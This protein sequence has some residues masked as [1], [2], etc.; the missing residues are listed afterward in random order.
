MIRRPPRSTLFPY[1]TLF[2][3]VLGCE[4]GLH[5]GALVVWVSGNGQARQPDAAV[6]REARLAGPAAGAA[7]H[8][9]PTAA[10]GTAGTAPRDRESVGEGKR[11]DIGG[12]RIN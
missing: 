1:T 2:R 8:G 3:S 10:A 4:L 6:T 5:G 7:A 9:R 12:R 11:G